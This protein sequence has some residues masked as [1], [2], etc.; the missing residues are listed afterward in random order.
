MLITNRWSLRICIHKYDITSGT[1][2]LCESA[3]KDKNSLQ[4][5][6]AAFSDK[7]PQ[8]NFIHVPTKLVS[9]QSKYQREV[10]RG[11]EEKAR[12][13]GF[14]FHCQEAVFILDVLCFVYRLIPVL[15]FKVSCHQ[16]KSFTLCCCLVSA[17][18]TIFSIETFTFDLQETIFFP[19]LNH[20]HFC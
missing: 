9:C 20:K 15:S 1:A 2:L 16:C 5:V 18:I 17:E 12:T 4:N 10:S 3:I 6:Q 19:L 11:W 8:T 14:V 7:L 13:E